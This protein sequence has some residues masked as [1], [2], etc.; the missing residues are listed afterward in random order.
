MRVLAGGDCVVGQRERAGTSS[1]AV[2]GP[3]ES[4]EADRSDRLHQ[5][6]SHADVRE[7]GQGKRRCS[8]CRIKVGAIDAAALGPFKK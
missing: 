1:R 4:H 3:R 2:H 6:R 5:V 8:Q 7:R